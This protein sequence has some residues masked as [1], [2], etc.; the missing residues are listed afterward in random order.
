MQQIGHTTI[1]MDFQSANIVKRVGMHGMMSTLTFRCQNG[2]AHAAWCVCHG[3]IA[4][5]AFWNIFLL[6]FRLVA[7]SC[8]ADLDQ[9]RCRNQCTAKS[10][11]KYDD[12]GTNGSRDIIDIIKVSYIVILQQKGGQKGN[13][14]W[15]YIPS[16][17]WEVLKHALEMFWASYM[18]RFQRLFIVSRLPIKWLTGMCHLAEH[19]W[20]SFNNMD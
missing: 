1:Q 5:Q 20:T 19:M 16:P 3:K 8:D 11:T 10:R 7:L 13:N 18:K 9:R 15:Q 17:C 4:K 14:K 12:G 6:I 2:Y